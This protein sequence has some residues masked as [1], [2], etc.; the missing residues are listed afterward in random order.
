M[1]FI[2]L[3]LVF[4]RLDD[5]IIIGY[6]SQFISDFGTKFGTSHIDSSSKILVKFEGGLC[7][8]HRNRMT[9]LQNSINLIKVLNSFRLSP[10]LAYILCSQHLFCYEISTTTKNIKF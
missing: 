7:G 6:W 10:N 3:D 9:F 5:G 2:S 8:S 1:M 4:C